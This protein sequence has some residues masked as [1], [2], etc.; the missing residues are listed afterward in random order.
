MINNDIINITNINID[1]I[2]LHCQFIFN[3][4]NFYILSEYVYSFILY[5]EKYMNNNTKILSSFYLVVLS[6]CH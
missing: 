2:V 3:Q 4:F 1:A 6:F 5:I